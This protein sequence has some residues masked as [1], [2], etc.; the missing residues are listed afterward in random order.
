MNISFI[1]Y[2]NM[3]K[4]IAVGLVKDPAFQLKASAPSLTNEIDNFGIQT[5]SDN[6]S[7]L[8]SAEVL[9]LAVKPHQIKNILTEIEGH[10]QPETIIVS[11]AAGLTLDWFHDNGV[12]SPTVRAMPN[13][14]SAVGKGA[15]P[16][17][18]NTKVT[19]KQKQ[20]VERIFN[21]TGITTWVNSD[22]EFNAYTALSG[23]GPAYVYLF[24]EAMVDAAVTLGIELDE[25]KK[26]ALQTAAGA[27]ELAVDSE[28]DLPALRRQV[29]SPGGTTEAAIDVFE[30]SN[31][32]HNLVREAM[33]ANIG[34]SRQLGE[35]Q[36]TSGD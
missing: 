31:Q 5:C 22:K 32:L 28:L 20:M 27:I 36:R 33:R 21:T 34:R 7:I 13:I 1:G 18:A 4:A 19:N 35:S 25:A 16:L 14:A 17:M 30:E 26:F 29:T 3:A 10:L 8:K 12:V 2:G 23:S 9:I 24:I 6:L 11:V 15:T